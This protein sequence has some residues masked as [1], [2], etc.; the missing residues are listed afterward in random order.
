MC[1]LKSVRY[2]RTLAN[3]SGY[4]K[5]KKFCSIKCICHGN[6]MFYV[7]LECSNVGIRTSDMFGVYAFGRR[8]SIPLC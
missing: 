1:W 8:V 2:G 3:Y 4:S 6:V 5:K 7:H